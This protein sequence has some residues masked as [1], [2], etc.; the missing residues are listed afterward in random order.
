MG[1]NIRLVSDIIDYYDSNNEKGILFL[2]DFQKA[3]DSL[4]WN[5]MIKAL[6][7]FNFGSSFIQWVTTLYSGPIACIKNNG[8]LSESFSLHRGIRQGCPASALLFII[9]VEML[10]MKIRECDKIKGFSFE[11][12]KQIKISQYADDCML[13]VNDI[14][15]LRTSMSLI[16]QFGL[17]SGLK[18]NISKC[19]G[20][21]L[22]K[23]KHSTAAPNDIGIKWPETVRYLGIYI[24]HNKRLNETKNWFD[25]LD[26]IAKSLK[27]W[28]QR[29]LS[30]YGKVLII[31]SLG[32]SKIV[33]AA[34][35]LPTPTEFTKKLNKILYSFIWGKCEKVSRLK[36]IRGIKNGGL[37]M[38]HIDS[39]FE[40]FK[41]NWINRY[42]NCDK[43]ESWTAIPSLYFK[44]L[45]SIEIIKGFNL[46]N[47]SNFQE[48]KRISCF[49][50]QVIIGFS[51]I[52][53]CN[54]TTLQETIYTQQIW[55]NDL[56]TIKR[57]KNK[58]DILFLRNWIKSGI[59]YIKDLKFDSAYTK[60][61]QF[62]TK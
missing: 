13:F 9:A 46:K 10:A 57:K 55:G 59:I 1:N 58:K 26:S 37:G 41:A 12:S 45:E 15:E 19:E 43:N 25:K 38:V 3:F 17:V 32:I 48:L 5:F 61:L 47:K 6:K 40:S 56:F 35:L 44:R 52:N 20:I 27:S 4:E 24:G 7:F 39:L 51:K 14:D 16:R 50:S 30:L 36:T 8:Y 49:W 33:L 23:N 54:N 34:T 11:D 42:I 22:G 60:K 62:G 29:D 2:A 21:W 53:G 18:L 31:K 28:R